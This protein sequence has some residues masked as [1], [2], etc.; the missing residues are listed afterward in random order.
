MSNKI[1]GSR[2]K[3]HLKINKKVSTLVCSKCGKEKTIPSNF[4]KN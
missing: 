2:K 1:V 3:Y 4:L